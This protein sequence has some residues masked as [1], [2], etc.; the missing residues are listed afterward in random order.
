MQYQTSW[1]KQRVYSLITNENIF[2]V[3][4][5]SSKKIRMLD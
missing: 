4:L 2:I 5:H 1:K 3:R